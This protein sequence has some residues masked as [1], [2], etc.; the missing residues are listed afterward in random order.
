MDQKIIFAVLLLSALAFG[1]GI[2][3][4]RGDTPQIPSFPWQIEFTQDGS[5]KVFGLTLGVSTLRQAEQT[6]Q[7]EAELSLFETNEADHRYVVEAYFD[8]A[9]PGG[10]SARMVMVLELPIEQLREM[11]Q[12]GTRI[13]SLGSGAHKVTL[14]AQDVARVRRA[15]IASIAYLPRVQLEKTVIEKRFGQP[16]QRLT[17][18]DSHTEH[19][20][21][22]QKGLDIALDN[23][24]NAVM[25]YVSPT[26]F[27]TLQKPLLPTPLLSTPLLPSPLLSS[28]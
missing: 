14:Q 8:K 15:P 6:L 19:W 9:N 2:L 10:L 25:Q 4:P 1:I 7:A 23:N 13:S 5:S 20:L 28:P 11:Y 27:A 12:R 17:E 16:E 18:Q 22:P 24:G 21:Y 3:I 26:R